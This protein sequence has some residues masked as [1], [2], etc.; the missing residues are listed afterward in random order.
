MMTG[1]IIYG[2]IVIANTALV[3]VDSLLSMVF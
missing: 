2:G 3:V 1:L